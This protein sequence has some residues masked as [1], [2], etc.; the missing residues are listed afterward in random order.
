MLLPY[1][2]KNRPEHF[3]YVTVGLIVINVLVFFLTT[4]NFF[5]FDP[6]VVEQ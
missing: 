5:S 3:P 4:K 1:R 2:A 6:R